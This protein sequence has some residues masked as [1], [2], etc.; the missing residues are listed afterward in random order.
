[1]LCVLWLG[2]S[3]GNLKPHEAVGFFQSVQESSGPNTQVSMQPMIMVHTH[4]LTFLPLFTYS[5][6]L[7]QNI[8]QTQYVYSITHHISQDPLQKSARLVHHSPLC[9]PVAGLLHCRCDGHEGMATLYLM[10]YHLHPTSSVHH[11]TV[12]HKNNNFSDCCRSSCAQTCGRT[13]RHCMQPTVT[14]KVSQRLSSRTA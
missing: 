10:A 2:S 13:P 14:A 1:M 11:C 5:K 3:V 4:K 9:Q 6:A 8:V 12:G 7:G